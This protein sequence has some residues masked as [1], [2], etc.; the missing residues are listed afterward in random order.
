MREKVWPSSHCRCDKRTLVAP[1]DSC[2]LCRCSTYP[3]GSMYSADRKM[4]GS[5]VPHRLRG[6]MGGCRGS[7]VCTCRCRTPRAPG[8]H[9]RTIFV[10]EPMNVPLGELDRAACVRTVPSLRR[11]RFTWR[12]LVLGTSEVELDSQ[13]VTP[14]RSAISKRRRRYHVVWGEGRHF[15][16][17]PRTRPH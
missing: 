8:H 3:R 9:V 11:L 15:P 12:T 1:R 5:M 16:A 17:H 4:F 13:V 2:R 14:R 6:Q 7:H 10:P